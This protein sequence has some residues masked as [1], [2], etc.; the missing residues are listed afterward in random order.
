MLYCVNF[1]IKAY[2]MF[3]NF[4]YACSCVLIISYPFHVIFMQICMC[5]CLKSIGVCFLINILSLE[6]PNVLVFMVLLTKPDDPV[7]QIG[8][9]LR[10]ILNEKY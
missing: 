5:E 9:F 7:F 1:G 3:V 2:N 10:Q 6:K 8:L 4:N